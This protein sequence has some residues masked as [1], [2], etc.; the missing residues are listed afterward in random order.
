MEFNLAFKE[1]REFI[2]FCLY[3]QFML[4]NYGNRLEIKVPVTAERKLSQT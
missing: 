1:L 3:R 4:P 2:S